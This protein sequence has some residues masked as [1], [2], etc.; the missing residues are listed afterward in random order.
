MINQCT[1]FCYKQH[2]WN[3]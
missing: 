2:S 3:L 1:I